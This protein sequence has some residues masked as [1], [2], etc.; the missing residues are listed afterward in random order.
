MCILLQMESARKA[1]ENSPNVREK[2]SPV[3]ST[4]PPIASGVSSGA[5]GPS[6]ANYSSFSSASVPQIP[7]ASVTPTTSLSGRRCSYLSFKCLT[8]FSCVLPPQVYYLRN[9]QDCTGS[10]GQLSC[11]LFLPLQP[12]PQPSSGF[13][14]LSKELLMTCQN[15][16]LSGPSAR[17]HALRV[18]SPAHYRYFK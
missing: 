10:D 18:S 15:T 7:V 12:P 1:W 3:T 9:I 16:L 6:A 4:A 14:Q 5:G 2:G 11:K 17:P 13:S 8:I